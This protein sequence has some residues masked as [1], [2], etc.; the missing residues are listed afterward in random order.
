MKTLT[1][2]YVQVDCVLHHDA[3]CIDKEQKKSDRIK[4]P[5]NSLTFTTLWAN[6]ADDKLAIFSYYFLILPRE[7][8]LAIHKNCLR[9]IIFFL[10]KIRK[11]FQYVVS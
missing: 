5:H 6:S 4:K 9:Q 3:K 2:D 11:M 1:K 8:N 10:G 7:Q